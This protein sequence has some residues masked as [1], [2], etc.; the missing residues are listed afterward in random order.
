[1]LP[2][3]GCEPRRLWPVASIAPSFLRLIS[4]I[5]SATSLLAARAATTDSRFDDLL[6]PLLRKSLKVFV[7]AF[8]LVF[9]ADNLQLDITGLVAGI[10][11][12]LHIPDLIAR[13]QG[14]RGRLDILVNNASSFY[15]T[16]MDQINEA[17]WEDL[18]GSNL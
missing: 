17:Q 7:A 12:G 5:R 14:F 9:I 18:M 1:M 8:G 6:V 11:L 10:G 3:V 13:I 15:P 4:Q 16:P 2:G